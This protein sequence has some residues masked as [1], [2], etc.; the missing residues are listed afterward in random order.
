MALSSRIGE[1]WGQFLPR[2]NVV[3]NVSCILVYLGPDYVREVNFDDVIFGFPN[4]LAATQPQKAK[5][6]VNRGTRALIS[7]VTSCC[8]C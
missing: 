4:N 3:F 5:P 8:V 7:L 6:A 1:F 2:L